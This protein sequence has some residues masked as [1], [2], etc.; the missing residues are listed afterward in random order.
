MGQLLGQLACMSENKSKL[1]ITASPMHDIG[2]IGIP[3]SILLK[4][5][6]LDRQEW[7][8]MKTH[9]TI[10]ANLLDGHASELMVTA[11]DIALTHHEKWDGSGYP[12]GLQGESIPIM[13]RLTGIV[14]VFDALSSK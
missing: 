8:I 11:R 10:G 3:D 6:M 4:P 12:N 9:T 14:D 5:D 2:K 7:Q 1:Y 13:G